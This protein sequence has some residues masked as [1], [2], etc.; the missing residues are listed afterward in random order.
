MAGDAWNP[1]QAAK[2]RAKA[3]K[4]NLRM[5][6]IVMGGSRRRRDKVRGRVFWGAPGSPTRWV[7]GLRGR[8]VCTPVYFLFDLLLCAVRSTQ[9]TGRT[10]DLKGSL[11]WL[12]QAKGG[13]PRERIPAFQRK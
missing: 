13:V 10:T 6:F 2:T 11:W 7:C 5:A 3:T 12:S 1:L 8:R 4:V 9:A